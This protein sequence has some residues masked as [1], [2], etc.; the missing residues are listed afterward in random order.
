MMS[1]RSSE[2]CL[3]YAYVKGPRR[4]KRRRQ[5]PRSLEIYDVFA[6]EIRGGAGKLD[7][8]IAKTIIICRTVYCVPLLPAE[9]SNNAA[10]RYDNISL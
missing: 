3:L 6:C 9:G 8:N 10:P 5:Q 1:F 7:K 2:Y 4:H